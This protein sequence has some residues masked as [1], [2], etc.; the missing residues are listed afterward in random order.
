MLN[1]CEIGK[2]DIIPLAEAAYKTPLRGCHQEIL[3]KMLQKNS[4]NS[5]NVKI[6]MQVWN[7]KCS[8]EAL[9]EAAHHKSW[10]CHQ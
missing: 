8:M 5:K 1:I 9:A 4:Q 7:G 6:Y 2:H 10:G 3:R